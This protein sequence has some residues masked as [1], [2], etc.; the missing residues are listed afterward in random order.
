[1]TTHYIVLTRPYL[2]IGASIFGF[3][4]FKDA[5]LA[6]KQIQ[7]TENFSHSDLVIPHLIHNFRRIWGNYCPLLVFHYLR[8]KNSDLV[9]YRKRDSR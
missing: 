3:G 9:A 6:I 1:M 2:S 4:I 5:L 7:A 8:K